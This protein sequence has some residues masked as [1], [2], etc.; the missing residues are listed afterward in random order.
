MAKIILKK[1]QDIDEE[2][3]ELEF[4]LVNCDLCSATEID[5]FYQFEI[6]LDENDKYFS[7]Y[8]AV[9]CPCNCDSLFC[10]KCITMDDE[11][12]L[13]LHH[14]FLNH[15]INM[16]GEHDDFIEKNT[17]PFVD[18]VTYNQY[19][20]VLSHPLDIQ[21]LINNGYK[22]NILYNYND[23]TLKKAFEDEIFEDKEIMYVCVFAECKNCGC[24]YTGMNYMGS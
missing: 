8:D 1:S 12:E 14:L 2:L 16:E 15:V 17:Q 18:H 10:P 19:N 7:N 5:R 22:K 11:N 21:L 3:D 13:T 6:E 24:K 9:T 20:W 23:Y 4:D